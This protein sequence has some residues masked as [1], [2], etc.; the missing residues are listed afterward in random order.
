MGD[1]KPLLSKKLVLILIVG[2]VLRLGLVFT[3]QGINADAFKYALTAERMAQ[4]GM[5]AGLRGDFFYPHNKL[6]QR[7]VVYAYLGSLLYRI[8]GRAILALRLVSALAGIALIAVVYVLC[9]ELFE[10]EGIAL[11]SAGL[12]A[13]QAEFLRAS[14]SVYREVLMGL[15][16]AGGQLLV[17]WSL[18]REKTWWLFAVGAGLAA[19]VSFLTRPEGIVLWG[20]LGLIALLP[21]SKASWRRRLSVCALLGVVFLACQVPYTLWMKS[22]T[23]YWM[24]NQWQI[25]RQTYKHEGKW[26][27]ELTREYIVEQYLRGE[28]DD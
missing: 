5:V 28:A 11:F 17:L 22:E 13:L 21:L 7:L 3:A 24:L 9:R 19:F 16:V 2:G 26:A 18:R 15:F 1:G 20:C 23:G 25:E 4:K 12:V 8:T 27:N 14:A 6:N 10:Q